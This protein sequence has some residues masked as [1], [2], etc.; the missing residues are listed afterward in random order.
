M[1]E[2]HTGDNR[3]AGA[4]EATVVE[5]KVL[6]VGIIG[7]VEARGL[8]WSSEEVVEKEED[9]DGGKARRYKGSGAAVVESGN[10]DTSASLVFPGST[11]RESRALHEGGSLASV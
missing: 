9:V 4:G 1:T 5:V 8:A 2:I 10:T 3:A 6:V 7:M 11:P